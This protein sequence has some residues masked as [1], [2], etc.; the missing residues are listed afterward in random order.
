VRLLRALFS[1]LGYKIF[2]VFVAVALWSA[3]QGFRSEE[4]SI[5]LSVQ[6]VAPPRG[7]VVIGQSAREV[8]L[9]ISGSRWAVQ[10][11]RS[12]DNYAIS[13]EE[14]GV[15]EMRYRVQPDLLDLPRGAKILAHSPSTI[16]V[17]LDEIIEKPVRVDVP[18]VGEVPLGYRLEGTE[19]EPTSVLLLGARSVMENLRAVSTETVNLSE[20]RSTAI[21]EVPLAIGLSHVW[22]VSDR[23]TVRVRVRV[24]P[25]VKA[26]VPGSISG[27]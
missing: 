26:E 1:N 2:A 16:S 7:L 5:E 9:K 3:T 13:L 23:A 4:A 25:D 14:A 20:I 27:G 19:V 8:N 12:L 6:L 17:K 18:V 15:G 22:P 24:V 11:A 10:Q 21:R